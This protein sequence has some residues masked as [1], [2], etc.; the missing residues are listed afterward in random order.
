MKSLIAFLA[1]GFS[2]TTAVAGD[3]KKK[4]EL[5]KLE[6][7]WE[8]VSAEVDGKKMEGAKSGLEKLTIKGGKMTAYATGGKAVPAFKDVELVLDPGK[9]PSRMDMVR[10][11]KK[12]VLPCIYELTGDRLQIA[13]PLIPKERKPGEGLPR[14]TSFDTEGKAIIVLVARRSKS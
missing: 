12:D 5:A 10:K 14:P 3:E 6:G 9:K 7:T 8:V 13:M 1:V 2:V 11:G 4:A